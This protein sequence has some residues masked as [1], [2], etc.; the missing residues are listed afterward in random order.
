MTPAVHACELT[1]FHR[2]SADD[3]I[4]TGLLGGSFVATALLYLALQSPAADSNVLPL[5]WLVEPPISLSNPAGRLT[6]HQALVVSRRSLV[7][8]STLCAT[9]LIVHVCAS[10]VT[11]ARHRRKKTIPDGELSHVPR[12][13]AKRAYLYV[14]FAV[15]VTLWVL[16]V[17][18]VLVESHLGV[19]QSE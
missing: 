10:R 19:W 6:A 3:G 14:L 11:E 18:I 7:S 15:S 12:Q 1:S 5:N 13:E 2:D 16:C 4:L 9:I 8:L 17:K